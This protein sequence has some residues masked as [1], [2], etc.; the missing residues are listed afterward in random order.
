MRLSRSDLENALGFVREAG[1]AAGDEPF[2]V[3][4]LDGLASLVRCETVSY[5]E[6]DRRLGTTQYA[7]CNDPRPGAPEDAYWAT[8]HEHPIRNHRTATGSLAVF[9]IYDFVTPAQLSKTQFY[10]DYIRPWTTPFMMSFGLPA[11]AGQTR[12]FILD[13]DESDFGERERALLE[14]L[15]PHLAQTRR[16]L[17]E[18]RRAGSAL[19]LAPNAT[20]TPRETEIL[21]WVAEGLT[22]RAIAERLWISPGTVRRHLDNIYAKLDVHTRGAAVRMAQGDNSEK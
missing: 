12:T 6:V 8:V 21:A 3:H 19:V 17:D 14:V 20:L 1:D 11:P 4:L 7:A 13:R 18:R 16:A 5:C 10:A 2:P 15:R 9:K 22:N